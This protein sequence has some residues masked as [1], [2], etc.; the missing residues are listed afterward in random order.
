MRIST[1]P[2]FISIKTKLNNNMDKKTLFFLGISILILVV[3]L[4]FVG[5]DQVISALKLAKLEY[6][7]IAIAMQVF[8]YYLYTLRWKI[9]N[10]VA[11]MDT[12]IKKYPLV[13]ATGS[14]CQ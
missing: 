1:K 4:Y 3:M 9:L 5:I 13:I 14:K 10:G 11:G 8:T 7:A 12:S 2:K 6:I